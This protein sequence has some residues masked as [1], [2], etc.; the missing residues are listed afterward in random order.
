VIRNLRPGETYDSAQVR[1]VDAS[2]AI[3]FE[4]LLR[5]MPNVTY[6]ITTTELGRKVESPEYYKKNGYEYY[7]QYEDLS[8]HQDPLWRNKHP[9]SAIFY[10][11]IDLEFKLVKSIEPSSTRSGSRIKIY[12]IQ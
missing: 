3:Y 4:L 9:K 1:I 10:D 5:N 2:S 7:I 11:T 6:D 12:E 8:F